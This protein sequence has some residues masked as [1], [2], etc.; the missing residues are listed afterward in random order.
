LGVP[1]LPRVADSAGDDTELHLYRMLAAE[2]EKT[3]YSRY[4]SLL[5]RIDSFARSLEREHAKR[6][7]AT[8]N[9]R[10]ARLARCRTPR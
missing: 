2:D 9:P 7:L 3:A 6:R 5:R 4:N 8:A 1:V 10:F